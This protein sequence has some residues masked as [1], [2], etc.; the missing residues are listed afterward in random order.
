[1]HLRDLFTSNQ[2]RLP[3]KRLLLGALGVGVTV[4]VLGLVGDVVG[5]F[6]VFIGFAPSALL[7]FALPE[8]PVSQPTAVV[9]GH[10]LSTAVGIVCG[11]LLPGTWWSVA[12]ASA[13]AVSGMMLLRI[14][15][16]PAVANAAIAAATGATW[17]FLLVP[18]LAAALLI[19]VIGMVWHRLS[20]RQYPHPSSIRK[21]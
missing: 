2:P 13:V 11:L 5:M 21:G 4:A 7:V 18:V 14:V 16:P 9:G 6:V 10:L 12:I 8:A 20:G 15:H 1:M 3:W 17:M 19:V